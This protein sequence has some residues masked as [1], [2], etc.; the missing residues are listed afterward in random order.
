MD[1]AKN[2]HRRERI[3]KVSVSL[4]P[5]GGVPPGVTLGYFGKGAFAVRTFAFL[6]VQFLRKIKE[7]LKKIKEFLKK[8]KDFLRKNK[9]CLKRIKKILRKSKISL[10]KS[11]NS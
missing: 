9:E 1:I 6:D 2:M 7:F 11:K 10:G 8:I 5:Q 3:A 4:V